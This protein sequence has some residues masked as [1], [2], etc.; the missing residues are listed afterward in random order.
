MFLDTHSKPGKAWQ[1]D[2]KYVYY[3]TQ[4]KCGK[5]FHTELVLFAWPISI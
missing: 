4:P 1:S 3:V 5:V 2:T